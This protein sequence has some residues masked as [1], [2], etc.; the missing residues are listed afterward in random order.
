M[1]TVKQDRKMDLLGLMESEHRQLLRATEVAR[2]LN[3][4]LETVYDWKYRAKSRNIPDG[5]VRQN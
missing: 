3:I 2:I 5:N 1:E 4:S